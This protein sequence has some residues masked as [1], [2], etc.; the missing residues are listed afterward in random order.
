MTYEIQC[1]KAGESDVPGPEV[2]W[3]RN[4]NTWET[5]YFTIVVVRGGGKTILINTGPPADLTRLNQWWVSGYGDPR[6]AMRRT[7]D[8]LPENA[9]RS[10]GVEPALVDY[11]LL[12]PLQ[13]YATANVPLFPNATI[14]ISR[15]GWIEDFHAPPWPMTMPRDL[16]IPNNVLV[17]LETEAWERVR[18]I[19]DNEEVLPGIRARW[20][21]THHRSSMAYLVDTAAGVVAISDCFFKYPNFEQNIPLGV[22]E[23]M[24][25]CLRS[26]ELIRRSANLIVPLYDPEVFKRHPAGR[27]P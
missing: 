14:C 4:W 9:L 17:Y 23:S 19:E 2:Y 26:Y 27:I 8:E 20:V 15:R 13:A 3:Q 7:A 11:V 22:Q 10:A 5:L 21:G 6:T 24:E 16:C 1:C 25:E 12:T 18:L